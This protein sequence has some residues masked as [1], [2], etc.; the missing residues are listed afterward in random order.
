MAKSLEFGGR[1]KNNKNVQKAEKEGPW[2]GHKAPFVV[3]NFYFLSSP[4]YFPLPFFLS[5]YSLSI[6]A[7]MATKATVIIA[8]SLNF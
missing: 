4:L 6:I 1:K 3:F 5:W 2:F 8:R 7:T